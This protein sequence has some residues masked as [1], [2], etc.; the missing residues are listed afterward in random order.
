MI[1]FGRLASEVA[2]AAMACTPVTLG[3]CPASVR[4]LSKVSRNDNVGYRDRSLKVMTR[5]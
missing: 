1:S 5:C 4:M 3:A 2:A